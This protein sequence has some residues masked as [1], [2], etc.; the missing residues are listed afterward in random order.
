M[1]IRVAVCG[2]ILGIFADWYVW[3]AWPMSHVDFVL[4]VGAVGDGE[5]G[6]QTRVLVNGLVDFVIP[7][8]F[9]QSLLVTKVLWFCSGATSRKKA[10]VFSSAPLQPKWSLYEDIR[11][12]M[13]LCG[14]QDV[15]PR[16]LTCMKTSRRWR[17]IQKQDLVL[18]I[19]CTRLE[20]HADLVSMVAVHFAFVH[21]I[22]I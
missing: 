4:F 3:Y 7:C 8:H 5:G 17:I 18:W 19:E 20:Y 11:P 15:K 14:L 21:Y 16:E 9:T 12:E 22:G 1:H 2:T 6:F 13:T 10:G